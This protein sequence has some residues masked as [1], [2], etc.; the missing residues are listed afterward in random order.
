MI[1]PFYAVKSNQLA[2]ILSTL[3]EEGCGFDCAS[4][5]EIRRVKQM[6]TLSSDI[7]YANPCKA[8]KD[9]RVAK[10]E[11]VE[12]CTFDTISELEKI[13]SEN[14][15]AK[16]VLRIHVD[17][18]GTSRIPLNRKFGFHFSSATDLLRARLPFYGIAYH[19]GSDCKSPLGYLSALD[20]VKKYV[21]FFGTA[22]RGRNT[23]FKPERLDIGGG[24]SGLESDDHL[25]KN[26]IATSITTHPVLKEFEH[27][28]AEPGRFFATQSCSLKVPVIGRKRLA[29]GNLALTIDESVYGMLSGV[30][31]DGFVPF[32][33]TQ[34]AGMSVPFTILGRTCDSADIIATN[35]FLPAEMQEG[36]V[37][38]V[39]NIGAYSYSSASEFN[40]FP[41][42]DID[43]T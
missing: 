28:I 39:K 6:N 25:F 29:D 36:D 10:S 42:P 13:Y 18:L 26:I 38:T 35:V 19:V 17:D 37:L 22:G 23:M 34:R 14:P 33:Q 41:K 1:R 20:M 15:Q 7:I 40:G 8:R 30:L 12:W 31:F 24:F 9:L 27:V 5:D 3:K 43:S 2:P 4:A 11:G 32:F 16:P 21:D